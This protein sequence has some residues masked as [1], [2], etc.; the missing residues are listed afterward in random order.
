MSN[1]WSSRVN[2]WTGLVQHVVRTT[3]FFTKEIV[4]VLRQPRLIASLV[5]GPFVILV[6]FGLGF[7]GQTPEFRTVLV[8]P[9]DP[10]LSDSPA[11]YEQ[12]FTG[13]FKL[14]EVTRDEAHAREAL[15]KHQTDVVVIVPSDALQQIYDGQSAELPVLYSETDPTQGTWVRYYAFVQTSELN[16]RILTEVIKQ[17]KSPAAQALEYSSQSRAE[18]DGL[19]AD[20]RSGNYV[21]AAAR[22]GRLL[23]TTRAARTGL[24]G[25]LDAIGGLRDESAAAGAGQTQALL[26]ANE[27]DLIG[28]QTDLAQG[29]AGVA[30]AEQRVQNVR[31]RNDQV[32]AVAQR[33]NSIPAETL[34]SPFTSKAQNVMPVEPT[35]I[36]F[37]TPAVLALLLQHIGVTLGALTSVR[38]RLLGALELYRVSPVAPA[39]ILVGKSLAYG[40][41]LALVGVALTAAATRVLGV[42]SLGNPI[43]FWVSLGLIIFA[44]VGLGFA[45]AVV[46]DTESQAVQ[47][48]MLVLLTSVFF[49]GFF[50]PLDQLFPWVR[51]VSYLLPVTYGAI[52]LREVMLRG[53]VPA[54]QYMLGPLVLG[55]AFYAVAGYGLGR[56][57][58]RA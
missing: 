22:T 37:Y 7:R 38:D 9:N 8:L 40:L 51:A 53:D 17:S 11:Q 4:G 25:A 35:A 46:A 48:S 26:E 52:D 58:R 16:R 36:A 12:G 18:I 49:G 47:L 34:V 24:A 3:G 41:L 54:W 39:H 2:L 20:L 30:S 50:L 1:L 31:S 55:L 32:E 45:L 19:D 23:V 6:L 29:P 56:Q 43:Y 5:L 33:M 21:S 10:S 14:Q 42:P 44:A 28:V 57:M 27:Q 13:V 15:Q